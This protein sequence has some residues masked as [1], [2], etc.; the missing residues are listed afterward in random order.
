MG[1]A[2]TYLTGL[3][4]FRPLLLVFHGKPHMTAERYAHSREAPPV[5]TGP[6]IVL[7]IGATVIGLAL[8]TWFVGNGW[9]EFWRDSIVIGPW[10]HAVEMMENIPAILGYLATVAAVAGI[11][12]V[13]VSYVVYPGIP[14]WLA[15]TFRPV[16]VFLVHKWY[17]DE[18]YDFMFVQPFFRVARLLWQVGDVTVIDGVPNGL[19]TLTVDSTRQV[20][21]LQTG[22]IAVYAF[23][24]LIG[25]VVLV[26]MFLLIR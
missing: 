22:S 11:A 8:E 4:I 14:A 9:K 5:M 3:Y 2:A 10:N 16:Y 12:T 17:F 21:K 25:L 20:V 18:L 1:I 26:S 13:F 6:L 15:T 19:A 7:A 23:S 24:M